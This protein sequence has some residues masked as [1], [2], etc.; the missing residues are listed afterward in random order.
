MLS[1]FNSEDNNLA[2]SLLFFSY[3]FFNHSNYTQVAKLNWTEKYNLL[4]SREV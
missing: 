1:V 4:W 2:L 3:K